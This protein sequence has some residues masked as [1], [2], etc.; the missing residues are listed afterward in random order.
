MCFSG[1]VESDLV[2]RKESLRGDAPTGIREAVCA[3]ANDLP[4]HQRPGGV[5]VRADDAGPIG[6]LVGGLEDK[7]DSHNRT[8]VDVT[9]GTLETRSSTHAPAALRQLVATR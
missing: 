2:E 8:A 6:S 1:D 4:D 5:F 7:L 9:S 3:F